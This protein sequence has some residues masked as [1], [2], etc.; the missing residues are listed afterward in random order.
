MLKLGCAS[1][2]KNRQKA[3]PG[4]EGGGRG[5]RPVGS[6]AGKKGAAA[7]GGGGQEPT[8][9]DRAPPP[10]KGDSE[11][12]VGASP[13]E[14]GP[15]SEREHRAQSRG[16]TRRQVVAVSRARRSSNPVAATEAQ[17]RERERKGRR[18][19]PRVQCASCEFARGGNPPRPGLMS[20]G[21]G[22]ELRA[23]GSGTKSRCAKR[24]LRG[25]SA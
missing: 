11:L 1:R 6:R 13:A 19:V 25:R 9:D 5:V 17:K 8:S 21:E 10:E 20:A 16:R 24:L 14:R 22:F 7:A 23:H 3:F 12:A 4:R 15:A 2:A 18:E